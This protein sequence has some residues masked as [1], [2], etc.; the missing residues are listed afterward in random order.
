M[1]G[2]AV[3]PTP[4]APTPSNSLASGS[5]TKAAAAGGRIT[6]SGQSSDPNGPPLVRVVSTM[7]SVRA[8]RDYRSTNGRFSVSWDGS[9][10]TRSVCVTVFDEPSGQGISLG[11]R[12]I[13]VK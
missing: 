5:I 4:A 8:V 1:N 3:A 10:G 13:I 9:K 11:C 7:G 12:D 2:S 6:I